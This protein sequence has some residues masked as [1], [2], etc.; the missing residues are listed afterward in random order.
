MKVKSTGLGRTLLQC[1]PDGFRKKG[2]GDTQSLVMVIT[3]TEPVHWHIECDLGG[4]DI[5]Q[6][7]AQMLKPAIVW[8]LIKLLISGSEAKG[9]DM[10]QEGGRRSSRERVSRDSGGRAAVVTVAE[11]G[12]TVTSATVK[13]TLAATATLPATGLAT[14]PAAGPATSGNG[15]PS[16]GT[17]PAPASA[18]QAPARIVTDESDLTARARRREQQRRQRE[19]MAKKHAAE[20]IGRGGYTEGSRRE[21]SNG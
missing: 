2:D 14:V 3:S 21:L 5:R 8:Q 20:A 13:P 9:F 15:T 4:K 19:E 11:A 12:A 17:K 10:G 1:H 6:M 18:R 7:A 16:N